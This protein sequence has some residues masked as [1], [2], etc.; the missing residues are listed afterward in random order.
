MPVLIRHDSVLLFWCPGCKEGHPFHLSGPVAWQWNSSMDSPTFTPSLMLNRGTGRQ[1]HTIITNGN[2]Q[3]CADCAHALKGQTVPMV[4][5]DTII[6]GNMDDANTQT[7]AP[8]ENAA[9]AAAPIPID[10][11]KIPPPNPGFD[12]AVSHMMFGGFSEETSRDIVNHVGIDVVLAAVAKSGAPPSLKLAKEP[13]PA[14][15]ANAPAAD[16]A[17]G[18]NEQAADT[19]SNEAAKEAG[20]PEPGM[21]RCATCGI[22]YPGGYDVC[23]ND[24]TRLQ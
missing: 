4:D 10:S 3:F 15:A 14:P 17:T 22:W 24:G 18:A 23:P 13:V 11:A 6:G 19:S 7:P 21:K 16:Q 8:A 20:P 2:I 5:W 9:A 12:R 1:C